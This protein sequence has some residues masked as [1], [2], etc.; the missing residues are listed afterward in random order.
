MIKLI[1]AFIAIFFIVYITLNSLL[2]FINARETE[3]EKIIDES[4]NRVLVSLV[5]SSFICIFYIRYGLS[6]QF[7]KYLVLMIFLIVTGYIDSCSKNVYTFISYIFLFIGL[8]FFGIDLIQNNSS[9]Y[10]YLIGVAVALTISSS[11]AIFKLLGWGDVEVFTI[12]AIYIGGYTSVLN[13]FLAFSIAGIG[14]IF[15]LVMGK[16]KLSDRGTLCPYIAV[17]TYLLLFFIL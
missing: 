1:A 2:K 15:K 16:V 4:W 17:S 3:N 9:F 7:I 14:T 6:L 5:S 11:I 10:S 13:I 8:I 12:A